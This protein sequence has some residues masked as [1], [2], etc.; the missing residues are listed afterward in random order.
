MMLNMCHTIS[1]EVHFVR[2]IDTV[3]KLEQTRNSLTKPIVDLSKK[4]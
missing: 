2:I 1:H 4:D 3:Y